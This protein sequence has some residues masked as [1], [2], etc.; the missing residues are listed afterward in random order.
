[1]SRTAKC[2]A[3]RFL[4]V[5]QLPVILNRKAHFHY[6]I[7]QTLEAGIVLTGT[8]VKSIRAGRA[9][10]AAAFARIERGQVWLHNSHIDEYAYGNIANHDPKRSRKLLL[11]RHEIERLAGQTSGKG[12]ALIP[13]KLYFKKGRVKVELAVGRGKGEF[14]KR[15][16]LKRNA[17]AREIDRTLR[18]VG[19]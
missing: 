4:F 15:E 17:A 10:I 8:E 5:K 9:Q 13:L 1:M 14:D 19:R 2:R 11:H 6:E 7:L 16:T 12:Y 18:R 3:V